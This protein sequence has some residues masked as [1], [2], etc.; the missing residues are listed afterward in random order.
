M[1]EPYERDGKV[2]LKDAILASCAAPIYFD[3]KAVGPY[4]L[5]DGGLW[6]NNPSII[7]TTEAVAKFKQEVSNIRILS[8]GTGHTPRMYSRREW[9]GFLT[10][11]G[12]LKL[13]AYTT[14]L[15]SQA[16][17]NMARLFLGDR[18][19]GWIRKSRTGSWMTPDIFP[20]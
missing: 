14:G 16:S 13:V 10:G 18:F 2:S 4:L 15:Q 5:A 19:L 7:A 6:A 8:L 17:T 20:F 9:W 12:G 11:W 1:G 3:P